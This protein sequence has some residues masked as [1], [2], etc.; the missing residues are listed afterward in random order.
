MVFVQKWQYHIFE[1]EIVCIH[2]FKQV[3]IAINMLQDI[4]YSIVDLIS[5]NEIWV[6]DKL[7]LWYFE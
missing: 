4:I 6:I 7:I 2:K 3:M 5:S 1:E